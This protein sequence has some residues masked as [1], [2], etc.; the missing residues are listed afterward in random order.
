MKN[1]LVKSSLKYVKKIVIL[2]LVK[3]V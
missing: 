3:A 1:I 2:K